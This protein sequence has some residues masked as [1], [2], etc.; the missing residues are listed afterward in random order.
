[1]DLQLQNE[2]LQVEPSTHLNESI[3]FSM[4]ER[5]FNQAK[6]ERADLQSWWLI[7]ATSEKAEFLFI[8]STFF[9]GVRT[10]RSVIVY[11]NLTWTAIFLDGKSAFLK[12]VPVQIQTASQLFNLLISCAVI[13]L[14]PRAN[15]SKFKDLES[16]KVV[17]CVRAPFYHI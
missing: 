11:P 15:N 17:V 7:S 16:V 1:M 8:E 12:D 9:Q 5:Q 14:C 10:S 3:K 2:D 4:I 13:A 6:S